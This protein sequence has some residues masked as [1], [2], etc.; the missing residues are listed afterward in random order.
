MSV[1]KTTVMS[2]LVCLS[3][4]GVGC[5]TNARS[6]QIEAATLA[7]ATQSWDGTPLPSYPRGASEITVMR[8]QI[9]PGAQRPVPKEPV[10]S[11]GVLTRGQLTVRTEEGQT[12]Y[13]KAGDSIVEVV[14]KWHYGVNEGTEPA[15][16]IVFY[17][18]TVNTPITVTKTSSGE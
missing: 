18:G 5:A 3:C 10:M 2:V 11:A 16:I 13:L 4:V 1:A 6:N 14:D 17:A 7:K 8:M 12:L 15:E 9:P